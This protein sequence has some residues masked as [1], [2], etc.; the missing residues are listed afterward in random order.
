[1]PTGDAD[2]LAL[3]PEP[4][5]EPELPICD[6]H[7]HLWEFRPEPVPYQ[8]DTRAKPIGS[9]RIRRRAVPVAAV[10]SS[11]SSAPPFGLQFES[12]TSPWTRSYSYN[13]CTTLQA[14]VQG[15]SPA[16]GRPVPRHRGPCLSIAV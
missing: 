12:N 1:M 16:S 14:A 2:W 9:V 4:T 13:A 11:S 5:L 7:H 8:R 6:A 3:T 10:L 15:Y